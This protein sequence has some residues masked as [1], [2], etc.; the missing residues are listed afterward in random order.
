MAR[1]ACRGRKVL[2]SRPWNVLKIPFMGYTGIDVSVLADGID[3]ICRN[4]RTL[5]A[6]GTS[7]GF[8]GHLHSKLVPGM[9]NGARTLGSIGIDSTTPLVGPAR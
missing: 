6:L 8:P 2:S 3:L 1:G 5:M 7:M 9:A 4:I